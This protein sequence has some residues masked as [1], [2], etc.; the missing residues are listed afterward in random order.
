LGAAPTS[1]IA[2]NAF[3]TRNPRRSRGDHEAAATAG[4]DAGAVEA[5]WA[6]ITPLVGVREDVSDAG[7]EHL[8]KAL[9]A[10]QARFGA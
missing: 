2:V 10:A 5:G 3:T 8:A 6:C 4:S 9:A 7:S 1:V